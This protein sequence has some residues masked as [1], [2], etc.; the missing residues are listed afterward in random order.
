MK[1]SPPSV[2]VTGVNGFVGSAL[3][4]ELAAIDVPF[5]AAS[6]LGGSSQ[7]AG[8]I[9][10]RIDQLDADTDWRGALVANGVVVH[11]AARVHVLNEDSSEAENLYYETNVAATLNLARQAAAAGV[12]RFIFVSSVKVNGEG[13]NAPFTESDR[14]SPVDGYARSKWEAEKGL[15]E[16]AA[17]SKMELVILRLP[18]V[19]GPG[20]KANFLRLISLV[21]R[22]VPLPFDGV[23]NRRSMIFL[24]NAVDAILTSLTAPGAKDHTFF[25]SDREDVSTPDLIRRLAIELGRPARLFYVP[26]AL[27]ELV[28][29]ITGRSEEIDRL[30][31]TLCVDS[32]L[33]ARTL[34]W[35]PP[36]SMQHGIAATVSWYLSLR[37]RG[38]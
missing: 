36:Y 11:L 38:S 14:P 9:D 21:D 1:G 27:I 25:L 33:I 5:V 6:R 29:K 18:L 20:V 22:G 32:N 17:S 24:G 19:Y 15:S 4:R 37:G 7:M 16:I 23:Q 2:L 34:G 12:K 28:G 10:F 13:Q 8:L 3:C 26:Q 31:G 30:L 35:R